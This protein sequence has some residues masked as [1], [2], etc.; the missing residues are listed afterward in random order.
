MCPFAISVTG[1][2]SA[3]YE[4]LPSIN[5]PLPIRVRINEL[6]DYQN[7]NNCYSSIYLLEDIAESFDFYK[8]K[9]DKSCSLGEKYILIYGIFEALYLQQ[10]ALKT[11]CLALNIQDFDLKL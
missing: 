10:D 6:T 7:Y 5:A 11:L 2:L 8:T 4:H 9:D 1:F 3:L